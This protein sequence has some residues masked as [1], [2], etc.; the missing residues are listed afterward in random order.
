MFKIK[1]YLI[2][3]K[4]I[5][6]GFQTLVK[7]STPDNITRLGIV[8]IILVLLKLYLNFSFESTFFL[9]FIAVMFIYRLDSRV[10]IAFGLACLI[11]C[12]LLLILFNQNIMLTGEYYAE[13]FAVFAYYFL[14]IGVVI[15][16]IEYIRGGKKR[17]TRNRK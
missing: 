13:K 6:L 1:N 4:D 3:P 2:T 14:C 16:I 9:L 11:C 8:L 12:P 10:S 5:Y 17:E 7:K 15:Q